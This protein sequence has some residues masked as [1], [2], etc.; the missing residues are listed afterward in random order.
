MYDEPF[1]DSS[2]I[3]TYLV[4]KLARSKVTVSLS[5]DGGDE[6]FGGYNRYLFARSIWKMNSRVPRMARSLA[7]SAIHSISPA[8]LDRAYGY[9]RPLVPARLQW[10]AI[11]DKAHK[12]SNYLRCDSPEAIY[13][14]AISHWSETPLAAWNSHDGNI[15]APTMEGATALRNFEDSMMLTDQLTYLPDD[16]LTKVDRAS[17]AVGL[18]ARVPLLDHRVVELAWRIPI[19]TKIRNGVSKWCLREVLYKYVPQALMEGPKMGF[20][21][22]IE[23]WLRGP[24]RGWAENLLSNEALRLHGLFNDDAIRQK[25]REHLSGTRNWQAMLWN[26]LVF[27]DWYLS[28]TKCAPRSPE[29]SRSF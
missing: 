5:G 23:H 28:A 16:I 12:F 10:A 11:G 13:M 18:E 2:Q 21:V 6:L 1:A 4:S 9:L 3:P 19:D 29:R 20:G 14:E 26:V 8:G 7:A 15:I 24:L 17:M 27:Q 22:P 25:W